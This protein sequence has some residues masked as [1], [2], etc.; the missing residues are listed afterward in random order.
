MT[1]HPLTTIGAAILTVA[2]LQRSLQYYQHNIGLRLFEQGEGQAT[3]GAGEKSL[4]HLIEQKGAKPVQRG[5]TGL[6]HFAIL[7]PSR[8]GL[9]RTLKHLVDTR[10]PI[11]GSSDHGVSEALYLSDPDGHG[12]EIYRDRPRSEWPSRNGALWMTLD[13]FDFEGVLGELHD[14]LPDW[15]GI[16]PDTTMGHLHLHIAHIPA[17]EYFYCELLGFDLMVR[18]GNQASFVAAGGY[19]HHLG[20]N[21]WAGIGAPP[22]TPDAARLLHYQILLPNEE[23]LVA[24]VNRLQQAG[25]QVKK[26]ESSFF[27]QD[28]AQNQIELKVA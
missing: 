19:H 9:A 24:V 20:L 4:L 12:I 7:T 16:H 5:R 2:D 10:T 14:E 23:A 6:Y 21:V 18:Y 13:P 11:G 15:Q 17:A 28:P 26:A 3:L 8:Y 25:Q 22:P 27:T 1:I